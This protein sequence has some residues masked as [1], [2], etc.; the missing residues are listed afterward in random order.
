MGDYRFIATVGIK[1]LKNRLVTLYQ[2][3]VKPLFFVDM[4]MGH[5]IQ[6]HLKKKFISGI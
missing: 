5:L 2:Q 4:K 1:S 6:Y 3:R